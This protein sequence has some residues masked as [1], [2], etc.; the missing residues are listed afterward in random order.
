MVRKTKTTKRIKA[1][2]EQWEKVLNARRPPK[3]SPRKGCLLPKLIRT[4]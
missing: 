4:F 3:I 1:D 2:D